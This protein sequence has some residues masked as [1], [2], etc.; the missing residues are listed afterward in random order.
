MCYMNP[1]IMLQKAYI[2]YYNNP[3]IHYKA[4][5]ALVRLY[6]FKSGHITKV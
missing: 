2:M 5:V 4:W 1:V 3:T 6:L